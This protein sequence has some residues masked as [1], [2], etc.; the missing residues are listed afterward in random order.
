MTLAHRSR[1]AG[2]PACVPRTA[3]AAITLAALAGCA[4]TSIDEN[5]DDVRTSTHERMGAEVKW[6]TTDEARQ[7]ARADVDAI[8]AG[9]LGGDDAVRIA[10]ANSPALQ[11]MLYEGAATAAATAQ[12]A[13]LPNP[14]FA[15]ERLARNQGGASEL[16]ITRT[17]S[18][19]VVDLLLL[20]SRLRRADYQQQTTRL[21]LAS[22]VVRV[23]TQ[24]R[25]AWVHAVAAQQ[26]VH[27]AEQVKAAADASAELARRMQAVGNFSK[28]QRAR[29][30]SFSAEAVV[31]LARSRQAARSTREALIRSLGLSDPG[32]GA[33][34]ARSPPRPSGRTERRSQRH[35]A[36]DGSTDRRAHGSL[37]ARV[38]CPR[39][40]SHP[41]HQ[42]R[43]RARVRC[44]PG[45][46]DRPGA[47]RAL[48]SKCRCRSST[49]GTP[50]ARRPRQPTWQRSIAPPS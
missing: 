45:Q 18:F 37:T 6:L 1:V 16:E 20:P 29:E 8:L 34:P 22:S 13:R 24:A 38:R 35:S 11:A 41:H 3:L 40:G 32:G 31:Q 15:F 48:M 49:S 5:F 12:S 14:V 9:P 23:A 50:A 4:S 39:A 44:Q 10:L 19:S 2:N 46:R 17:L 25:E 28:L 7:Q 33:A 21:A 26:S 27:Y 30:Q 43:Q 47:A 36:G 42:L